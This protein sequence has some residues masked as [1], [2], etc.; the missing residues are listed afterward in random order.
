MLKVYFSS[1]MK[2]P[3]LKSKSNNIIDYPFLS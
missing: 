3:E 1:A 2:I